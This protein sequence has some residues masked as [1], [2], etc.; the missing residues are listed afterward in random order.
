MFLPGDLSED[1]TKD[2]GDGPVSMS[3]VHTDVKGTIDA[4]RHKKV[5]ADK[6]IPLKTKRNITKM[7][8]K[9]IVAVPVTVS[10]PDTEDI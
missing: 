3:P 1:P 6:K 5:N 8:R 4:E 10:E 2:T 7:L 9:C